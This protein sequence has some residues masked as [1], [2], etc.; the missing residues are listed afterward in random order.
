MSVV[1][2]LS[3]HEH[4]RLAAL[5]GYR[6]LDT[7]P[8]E[9]FDELARLA[10]SICDTP[11]ALVSLVDATR[12]W[13]KA[14]V[15]IDAT[16][17]PRAGSFCDHAIIDDDLFIVEDAALDPR[18]RT[19]ALVTGDPNIRFYAGA[20]LVSPDG[21]NL[22]TLCVIDKRPRGLNDDQCTALRALA[23]QVM[24]Q[25]ELRRQIAERTNAERVL[26]RFFDLSID[27]LCIAGMDGRFR[28]LNPAFETVLGYTR[29]ELMVRPFLDYVHPDDRGVTAV[30]LDRLRRGEKTV[31]FENRYICKDGSIR[32]FA[33]T[34]SP[35]IDDRLIYAAARDVT[36]A[37]MAEEA[38][39]RSEGRTRSIIDN[40]LGGVITVNS[41][42]TIE[43]VNPAAELMFGC[44]APE[45]V[46]R[47]LAGLM[48][49]EHV[50]RD[51]VGRV[52]VVRARRCN[53][54]TFACEL[55]LFEF[56][57][58]DERR[59]FAA[60][61]LDITE[62]QEVDRLKRDFVSTVS[63]E[64][65]TPLT[66]I[67]GSLGL[68]GAGVMG[69]LPPETRQLV[70]VAERNCVRLIALINEILDFDKLESGGVAME[71]RPTPLQRILERS[72]ETLR[73][74]AE[75]EGVAIEV[76]KS[77]ATVLADEKR[78]TQVL[79]NLL[80]NAV[81]YSERGGVV[82]VSAA[83]RGDQLE[84]SVVDRGR[85]IAR[86]KLK[87]VFERFHQIDSSDARAKPGA[88]LGLAICKAIVEKH[89]G[90]IDVA[91]REGEGSRF[92]FRIAGVTEAA[93]K[94]A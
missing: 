43:S 59:H 7:T 61:L 78:I 84:I 5:G 55:S 82:T 72:V 57:G 37:K 6:I 52:S 31:Q 47:E 4:D 23:R 14:R 45:L 86:D 44:A 28:R 2:S 51:G 62:R 56:D 49:E 58:G 19:N 39:R 42:G 65:R 33:W 64:L 1:S 20:P 22:G 26:D 88:G 60:H 16:E 8:E 73:S 34:A 32:Y 18:F 66:S 24:M 89:G 91:S 92:S 54:E 76:Q 11:I 30:E 67:R 94:L 40:A 10:S 69:D 21:H 17:T 29:E 87:K 85:G 46:G 41:R 71:L 79:V 70:T 93:R 74:F 68:L 75:Q 77:D 53:G 13:F 63:H 80:S 90:T 35:A 83:T 50:L 9:A 48:E 15:G 3:D 12:Q 81:K 25:L 36:G 38:L 27:L